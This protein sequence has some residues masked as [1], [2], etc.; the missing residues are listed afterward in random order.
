MDKDICEA[1]T[2]PWDV[3]QTRTTQALMTQDLVIEVQYLG[4]NANANERRGVECLLNLKSA[5]VLQC[6]KE[7]D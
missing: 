7:M 3:K 6:Q 4:E 1:G 5:E 2:C